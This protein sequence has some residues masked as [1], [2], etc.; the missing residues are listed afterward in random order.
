MTGFFCLWDGDRHRSESG[1]VPWM[2]GD[3]AS[4]RPPPSRR[5]R[6]TSSAMR[7]TWWPRS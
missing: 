7:P 4:A 1:V 6:S 5:G 2:P 3:P